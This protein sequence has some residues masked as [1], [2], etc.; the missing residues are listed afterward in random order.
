VRPQ[1]ASSSN[2]G[3]TP[4]RTIAAARSAYS[5]LV[6]RGG[7]AAR[8]F[9]PWRGLRT[10][11]SDILRRVPISDPKFSHSDLLARSTTLGK[12]RRGWHGPPPRNHLTFWIRTD[13]APRRH[14]ATE[15]T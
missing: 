15:K 11:V 3:S 10:Y 9:A 13:S 5:G 4:A 1:L 12:G 7:L 2:P 8:L 14:D 6:V